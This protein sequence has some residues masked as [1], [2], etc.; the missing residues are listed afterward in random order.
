M[1]EDCRGDEEGGSIRWGLA[2]SAWQPA[3]RGHPLRPEGSASPGERGGGT[4]ER[5]ELT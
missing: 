5:K 2:A 4:E 3:R 1:E